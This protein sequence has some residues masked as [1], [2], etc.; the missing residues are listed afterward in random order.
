MHS[1][2]SLDDAK[3]KIQARGQCASGK[4]TSAISDGQALT[5]AIYLRIYSV[6]SFDGYLYFYGY[7]IDKNGK[8][9]S[10]ELEY[11]I[12][13]TDY[14]SQYLIEDCGLF[15]F[16]DD[17]EEKWREI[18]KQIIEDISNYLS[19]SDDWVHSCRVEN[20]NLLI[21]EVRNSA[22]ESEKLSFKINRTR[23]FGHHH[24]C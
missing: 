9:L 21:D 13:V 23:L 8:S 17:I 12:D 5:M 16:F 22:P 10:K 2:L 24:N 3:G 14:L 7:V 4:R 20:E 19:F 11:S 18:P 15:E 1:F 6:M